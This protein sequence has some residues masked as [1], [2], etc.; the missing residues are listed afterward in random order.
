MEVVGGHKLFNA[1]VFD[2][3]AEEEF[4]KFRSLYGNKDC[5]EADIEI[6]QRVPIQTET[7]GM[8]FGIVLA[9]YRHHILVEY[10]AKMGKIRRSIC[11][12]DLMLKG[13]I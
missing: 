12:G 11:F 7:Q 8:T 3:A 9:K 4:Q 5:R 13:Y 6:G 2:K 1:K 10:T